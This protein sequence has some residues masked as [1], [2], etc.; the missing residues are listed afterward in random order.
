MIENCLLCKSKK[1]KVTQ[2]IS[3][4]KLIEIYF[5]NFDF[6]ISSELN[7]NLINYYKCYSC[8]LNFFDS[9]SAGDAKFYEKLQEKRKQY[10]NPLRKEFLFAERYIQ[11]SD[12]VLEIGAG[13]GH[14]SKI[15]KAKGYLGLEFNDRAIEVAN[16]E[17]VNLIKE[18]IVKLSVDYIEKFDVVCSFHV[19]E[20]VQNPYQF[21]EA[22]LKTLRIGG[23]LI[24]AVPCNN[25][26]LTS[27][28]NHV[29][30]MPPHHISRYYIETMK[31]FE[32]KFSLKIIDYK[33]D[34]I[35]NKITNKEYLTEMIT[36]KLLNLFIPAE[37]IL[38]HKDK[39]SKTKRFI[40]KLNGKFKLYKI[41]KIKPIG[42]N[43]TF[44]Y[45]K[46]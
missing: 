43:M 26:V 23:Y 7:K 6:D 25:S 34:F 11:C 46:I 30:N 2:V 27:N 16:R 19:L 22:A 8:G 20:H 17:G 3:K 13:Y 1:I 42:E 15:I 44:V 41:I 36:N 28:H 18:D 31:Y 24:I 37:K 14:F 29:L 21:I 45:K 35:E 39:Y 10:Y 40:H 38:I 4:E 12:K 33:L 9:T 32:K 5:D